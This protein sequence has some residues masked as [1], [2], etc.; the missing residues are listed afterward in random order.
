MPATTVEARIAELEAQVREFE[1]RLNALK[2]PRTELFNIPKLEI[3]PTIPLAA[4]VSVL[5]ETQEAKRTDLVVGFT[6]PRP[7]KIERFELWGTNVTGQSKEPYHI[8]SVKDSPAVFSVEADQDTSVAISIRTITKD[9]LSSTLGGSPT[10]GTSIVR[11]PITDIEVADGSITTAKL[12]DLAVTTAKVDNAAITNAKIGNAEI[13]TAKIQNL[14]VT[15]ALINDLAAA[16]ITAG[17]LSASVAVLGT[18]IASQVLAGTMSAVNMSAG[19]FTLTSGND[20]MT[21]DGTNGF[22]QYN[23]SSLWQTVI[24]GGLITVSLTTGATQEAL[25]SPLLFQLKND[26]ANEVIALRNDVIDLGQSDSGYFKVGNNSG[27]ARV[28]IGV[29]SSDQ[30]VVH[31]NGNK[32]L[33]VRQTDPGASPTTEQ[34]RQVLLAHGLI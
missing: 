5:A 32:V 16:K 22:R 2:K 4:E 8:T 27:T 9:G 21:V 10:I 19:T 6:N 34:L 14:A 30:G 29:N 18:V 28:Q 26:E 12:A 25:V 11:Q 13:S 15:N 23:S 3:D 24:H 20:Q 31:I 33:T 7:D 17:N 1:D